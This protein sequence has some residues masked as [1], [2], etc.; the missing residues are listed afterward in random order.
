MGSFVMVPMWL[1]NRRV[2]PSALTIYSWLASFGSFNPGTGRYVECRPALATLVAHSGLS[3][4]TITR[5]VK[6]LLAAGALVP[7]KRYAPDGGSLPTCYELMFH[8][9]D[10]GGGGVAGDTPGVSL[11][12]PNQEPNTKKTT[13]LR[14]VGARSAPPAEETA[15]TILRDWIDYLTSIGVKLPS[16]HRARYG[17]GIK[18]LLGDGFSART[19]KKALAAMTANG[20]IHRPMMLHETVVKLQTGPEVRDRPVSREEAQ[21][22]VR[23]GRRARARELVREH[24]W[25]PEHPEQPGGKTDGLWNCKRCTQEGRRDLSAELSELGASFG[26]T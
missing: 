10:G 18:E 14:S 6:E 20:S 21:A 12:T 1:M 26:R 11:A 24:G 19:I 4:S 17:R 2:S 13:S 25:C 5:C 3:E 15:Q 7:R 9:P 22:Q 23:E 8:E 16:H